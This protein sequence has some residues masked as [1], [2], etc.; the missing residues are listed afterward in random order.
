M[1]ISNEDRSPTRISD[2]DAAPTPTGRAE[3]V[4]DDF[5]V[6]HA[7]HCVGFGLRKASETI[8]LPK[9]RMIRH[10]SHQRLR[11]PTM[12]MPWQ[13]IQSFSGASA[14]GAIVFVDLALIADAFAD[15]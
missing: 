13:N 2:C 15:N 7:N 1:R 3:F 5:P 10:N 11:Q 9:C 14:V 4:S 12:E 6:L 8:P